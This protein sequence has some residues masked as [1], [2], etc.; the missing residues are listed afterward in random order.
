MTN[1]AYKY[2]HERPKEMLD[3]VIYMMASPILNHVRVNRNIARIFDRHFKGRRCEVFGDPTMV[4]LTEKDRVVPD[5]TVV[6]SKDILKKEGVVGTPDLI[7]ET[8]SPS[9]AKHDKGYKKDLYECCGVK[10]YW[11]ADIEKLLI[12]TYWLEDG[13]Y[14]LNNVYTILPDYEARD[15][16][17]EK[18]AQYP[19]KF[20]TSLFDD[21]IIDLEEIFEDI[22]SQGEE[23][24]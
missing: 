4:F 7:V 5:V 11:I 20:K 18:L 1:L 3:G 15:M 12:E 19:T 14:Q 13:K 21:L 8:L 23:N 6:C 17:E 9:T 2:V 22:I 16:T 24:A 10:E